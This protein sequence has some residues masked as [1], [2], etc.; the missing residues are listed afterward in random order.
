MQPTVILQSESVRVRIMPLAPSA[1]TSWHHHSEVTDTM[2]G[3]TGKIMIEMLNPQQQVVLV[4]G[5]HC[6]VEVGRR[7]RVCNLLPE[8]ASYLLVQGIGQYDF[9][10]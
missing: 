7:H 8:E 3:M 9:I 10:E 2:V 6:Q 1:A 5:E 4:P